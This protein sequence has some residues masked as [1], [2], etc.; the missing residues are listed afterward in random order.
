MN[1][2]TN[3]WVFQDT[4][5]IGSGTTFKSGRN[6][7]LTI[8]ITGDSTSRT[9]NFEGCDSENN[10]YSAPAIRL[11]E[12][13]TATSTTGIN[14]VWSINLGNWVGI[15]CRISAIN[16]GTVKITGRVVDMGASLITNIPTTMN[17]TITTPI[18]SALLRGTSTSDGTVTTLVDSTKNF[19]LNSLNNRTIKFAVSNTEYIRN[20]T[21]SVGDTIGFA[22]TQPSSPASVTVT[23]S[24]GGSMVINCKTAGVSG[25]DYSVIL[26]AGTGIS[27]QGTV[28]FANNL[29]TI[30]SPTDVDGNP[31]Q[32][33]P[34]NIETIINNTPELSAIFVVG[35]YEA[36]KPL[37]IL[38]ESVPFT[39]G[40][41]GVIVV[42]GVDYVVF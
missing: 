40:S 30:T 17:A 26:V 18:Q 11:P 5:T 32:I 24:T 19:E 27:Q 29:L 8:Y 7:Q 2:Q 9:I 10:W 33:L 31:D 25:N 13:T 41:D 23:G 1:I 15:R 28:S 22:D 39:G 35:T 36:G 4:T 3:L 34:G 20:I 38:S 14:E 21:S 16:G 6:D 42:S 12:L 37:D